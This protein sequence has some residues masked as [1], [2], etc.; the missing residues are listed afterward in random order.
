MADENVLQS[1][2]W[3]ISKRPQKLEDVYGQRDIINTFKNLKTKNKPIPNVMWF[4]GRYGCG[5]TTIAKIIAKTIQCK[6]K[7]A[8]GNPCNECVSCKAIENETFGRNTIMFNAGANGLVDPVRELIKQ[9]EFPPMMDGNWVIMVEEAQKL[10][11]GAVQALL[12]TVEVPRSN[13]YFIFTSM[14]EDQNVFEMKSMKNFKALKSRCRQFKVQSGSVTDLMM[15]MKGVLDAENLWNTLPK[16]FQFQGLQSIANHS[17]GSYRTAIQTLEECIDGELFTSEA[18]TDHF[19]IVDDAAVYKALYDI[20]SGTGSDTVKATFI[21]GTP[22]ARK[23]NFTEA[24]NKV[25]NSKICRTFN[26]VDSEDYY[27]NDVKA[28]ASNKNLDILADGLG[29]I[30]EYCSKNFFDHYY[31]GNKVC[32]LIRS[33]KYSSRLTESRA[34][35]SIGGNETIV[36]SI[37]TTTET[38]A[39]PTNARVASTTVEQNVVENTDSIMS[40][41]VSFDNMQKIETTATS[42]ISGRQAPQRPT[43]TQRTV[44]VRQPATRQRV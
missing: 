37:P 39:Q 27:A 19:G 26:S 13:V 7:D 23:A 17:N 14:E 28:L 18:L 30:L 16:E 35:A 33:C 5:K 21:N 38:T 44:G 22:E 43:T 12:K 25:V 29:E 1:N 10:V 9:T 8:D 2:Q 41:T 15:Y 36:T 32:D 6:N 24:F 20:L 34:P 3:S 42:N 4:E 11:D 31:C 40:N